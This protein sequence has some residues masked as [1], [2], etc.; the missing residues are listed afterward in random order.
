MEGLFGVV[1]L[2]FVCDEF[3]AVR[4]GVVAFDVCKCAAED[5]VSPLSRR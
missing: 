3:E 2:R 4:F 1:A 5:S